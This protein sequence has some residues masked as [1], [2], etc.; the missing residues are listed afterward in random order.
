VLDEQIRDLTQLMPLVAIPEFARAIAVIQNQ[1]GWAILLAREAELTT[2]DPVPWLTAA[3]TVFGPGPSAVVSKADNTRINLA[4]AAI[5]GNDVAEAD[6][7][8]AEIVE[9]QKLSAEERLWLDLVR[10][11]TTLAHG[12]IEEAATWQANL[13]RRPAAKSVPMAAW[14]AAWTRGLVADVRHPDQA[15]AAY[16]EAEALLEGYA[17]RSAPVA[18]GAL[19]EG[20]YLLFAGATRRLI[21]L[22]HATAPDL[23][24]TIARRARNRATRMA[25]REACGSQRAFHETRETTPGELKLLFSRVSGRGV[26]DGR[27]GWIG[28][29]ITADHVTSRRLTLPPVPGDLHRRPNTELQS[30]SDEL[31][32]P[33]G[34]EIDDADR[35]VI[36]PTED[37]H[38]VPFHALPW[39]GG[40]LLE[41]APVMYALDWGGCA[42]RAHLAAQAPHSSALILSG[43]EPRLA[44]EGGM[45]EERYHG[46]DIVALHMQVKRSADLGILFSERHAIAHLAAHGQHR[47]GES[48]LESD[49]KL[50]FGDNLSLSR[51]D[52]L[53][54]ARVP[55]LVHLSACQSSFVDTETLGGGVSVAQAFLLRG[56]EFV[57]GATH[58]VDDLV[59]SQFAV[60]FHAEL[61]DS[62]LAATP[63]VWQA[64]YLRV[65]DKT[66]PSQ[67]TSLRMLRLYVP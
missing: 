18:F 17:Q 47:P 64:A 2:S 61:V 23:A 27:T 28:F 40:Q 39:A 66:P 57:V 4:L 31:L 14:F 51:E 19:G 34:D 10:V 50:R 46:S 9:E 53:A 25:G 24:A 49:D 29:A 63:E 12:R 48:W 7:W 65:S 59:A 55:A 5:Q 44:R 38:T 26:E 54:G 52:V 42:T 37:L 43:Q 33:F 15:V 41:V 35:I 21:D 3:L 32:L 22:L 16:L 1:V 6:R 11:R 45:V 8:I 30:W 58:E 20:R 56:S 67:Y 62:E 60:A 13:L 36:L